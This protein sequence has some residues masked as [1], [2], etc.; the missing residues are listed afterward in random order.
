MKYK[1][2]RDIGFEKD[3]VK[4]YIYVSEKSKSIGIFMWHYKKKVW[5]YEANKMGD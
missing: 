3:D 5:I 1:S 2:N 4:S